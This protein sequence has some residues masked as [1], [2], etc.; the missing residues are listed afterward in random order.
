MTE[1][2]GVFDII[3]PVMV[4]PSSSH[5]AGAVRLGLLARTLLDEEPKKV[6]ILLHGSFKETLHGHGTDLAIIS[7]LLGL[8]P[9]DIRIKD[10]FR[11]AKEASLE[12]SF[13]PVDLDDVHPNTV[14]F[15]V[16][17]ESGHLLEMQGSSIGGGNIIVTEVN[18]FKVYITGKYETLLTVHKDV[19]G[20]ISHVAGL[21]SDQGINVAFM[22]VIREEKGELAAMIIETDHL[23]PRE[24]KK[25]VAALENVISVRLIRKD[26]VAG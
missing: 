24:L 1:S 26:Q 5:T 9:N 21:L 15:L 11:L 10:A 16:D 18:G 19:P 7:G 23:I 12:Y 25:C 4:G 3:G 22:Q 8:N 14:R 17:G 6:R 2:M 13:E 20:V